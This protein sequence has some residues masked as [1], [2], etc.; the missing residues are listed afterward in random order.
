MYRKRAMK[1]RKTKKKYRK[2]KKQ[3]KLNSVSCGFTGAL[4]FFAHIGN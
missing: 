2:P 4:F 3:K 1:T